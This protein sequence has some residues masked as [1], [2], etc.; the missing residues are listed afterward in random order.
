MAIMARDNKKEYTTAPEGLWPAVCCDV[1]DLG[2]VETEW[3]EKHKVQIRWQLEDLDPKT[4]KP[5]LV[6]RKFNLS[7]HEKSTL[8]PMLEAWRGKKFSR[9]ELEGFD[10]E[11]LIAVNCQIQLI[12]NIA[13]DGNTYAN[14]QAVVP[15]AK[16]STKIAVREYTRVIDREH[17]EELEQHPD[18]GKEE[19]VPF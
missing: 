12:H 3:G 2:M 9:E 10:L 19:W 8:R 16:G 14:V 15:P 13:T 5:F 17:Q 6:S 7:L 1:V 11:R 4:Q 18:G